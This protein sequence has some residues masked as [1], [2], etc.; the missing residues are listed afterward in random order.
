MGY[1][2]ADAARFAGHE[3]VLVSGPTCLEIPDGVEGVSVTS[4]EEM[5]VAVE[6]RIS[7]V[8][9]AV[10]VAAVADYRPAEV[11]E[12][13]IK[14]KT[15]TEGV[16]P[17]D[18]DSLTLRLVRTRDI[19]G[20]ARESMGFQ[21]V[22]VGFAAETENLE[23]N[24]AGKLKRKGCDL[25]VANDVSGTSTGFGSE[26]NSVVLL[27]ADGRR[28]DLGRASKAELGQQLVERIADIQSNLK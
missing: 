13:K 26:D 18:G 11:A 22:L 24:A 4:A 9:V 19:L 8:D 2:L 21:G 16:D 15:S 17:N 23:V 5:F 10:M 27:Y 28:E 6:E 3:V 25:L 1:A 14:K 7:T 20:S 12:Q